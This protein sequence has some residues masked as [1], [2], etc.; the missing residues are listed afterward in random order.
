MVEIATNII[1]LVHTLQTYIEDALAYTTPLRRQ[2][3]LIM[4]ESISFVLSVL[5]IWLSFDD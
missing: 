1:L 4:M 3:L 2:F 5:Q